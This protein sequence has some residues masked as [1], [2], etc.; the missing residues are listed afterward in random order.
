[1]RN[2]RFKTFAFTLII[3]L[4]SFSTFSQEGENEDYTEILYK[5]SIRGGAMLHAKGWGLTGQYGQHQTAKRSFLY[6][7]DLLLSMKHPKETKIV[8]PLYDQA[9]PYVYGKKNALIG[10][11]PGIGH[12]FILADKNESLGVRVSFNY[13]F[14]P[15][16]GLIKPVFLEIIQ[17]DSDNGRLVTEFERYQP[18]KHVDQARIKGGAPFLMGLDKSTINW[19]I[20]IKPNFTFDWGQDAKNYKT[21]ET[22][23]MVDYFPRKVPN[24]AFI[25]NKNFF[26]NLYVS[27]SFGTRW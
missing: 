9:K 17:K 2:S 8:N 13:S 21:L 24:F 10:I 18:D 4:L 7:F 11:K 27:F 15:T 12:K 26:I 16:I 6:N 19:G 25:E 22:G 20:H 5:N 3:A 23:L 14:G 1:M